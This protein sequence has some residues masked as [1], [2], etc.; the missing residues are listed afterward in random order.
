MDNGAL[1]RP[2]RWLCPSWAGW[3]SLRARATQ[4][5]LD[6]AVG[7]NVRPHNRHFQTLPLF[8]FECLRRFH[9]PHPPTFN[10][11]TITTHTPQKESSGVWHPHVTCVAMIPS[12]LA[13]LPKKHA[14]ALS[15]D[16]IRLVSLSLSLSLC[17]GMD[18]KM[19]SGVP[20]GANMGSLSLLVYFSPPQ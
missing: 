19:D 3:R 2:A 12:Q 13:R 17:L 9:P 16:L 7:G 5:A 4:T 14:A 6:H 1:A 8:L 11:T 10:S 18:R 15:R 20:L